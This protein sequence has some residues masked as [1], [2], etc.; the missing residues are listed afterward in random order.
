MKKVLAM[1]L[2]AVAVATG[3][4]L[5]QAPAAQAAAS[6]QSTVGEAERVDVR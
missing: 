2:T 3:V 4:S 6:A 1:M 5:V